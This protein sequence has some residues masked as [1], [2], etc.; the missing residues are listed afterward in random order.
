MRT[1]R[2]WIPQ[3]SHTA[4]R[5]MLVDVAPLDQIVPQS[6]RGQIL[7]TSEYRNMLTWILRTQSGANDSLEAY[8][9]LPFLRQ[10]C[11]A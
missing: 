5:G 2:E 6:T 8:V 9:M 3:D 4:R 11:G 1:Q 7:I 10:F